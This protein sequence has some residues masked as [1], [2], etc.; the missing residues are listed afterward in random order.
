MTT[1]EP[2]EL[3]LEIMEQDAT[4]GDL[5]MTARRLR[6][7]IDQNVNVES[8]TL[9]KTGPAPIGSKAGEAEAV[10]TLAVQ[11]LPTVI[12][13]LFGL[14]QDWVSRGRGRTVKFKGMGID[15]EGSPEDLHILL[16][17]LEKT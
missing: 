8:V 6:Q 11:V 5:N 4:E 3:E 1:E 7:E 13:S 17:K 9:L 10:S 15:F 12:S 16:D 14:V 2:I